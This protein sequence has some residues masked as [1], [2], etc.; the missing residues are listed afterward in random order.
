MFE[1]LNGIFFVRIDQNLCINL[2]VSHI[3]ST[4]H[5]YWN[6]GFVWYYHAR[7]LP[8]QLI[9][10]IAVSPY[11][12]EASQSTSIICFKIVLSLQEGSYISV[13]I[14]LNLLN[15]LRKRGLPSIL[16]SFATSLINAL[17]LHS[18]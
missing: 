2:P 10:P 17:R 9:Y 4:R 12:I 11:G 16:S 18:L 13:H 15:V 7:I 1:E 3:Q 8:I 14:L 6:L 5:I